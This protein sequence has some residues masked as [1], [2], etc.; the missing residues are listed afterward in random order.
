LTTNLSAEGWVKKW[1][2]LEKCA[3]SGRFESVSGDDV[4]FPLTPAL[5]LGEREK[6]CHAY[7]RPMITDFIQRGDARI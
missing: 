1:N 6:F 4:Y 2:F 5:S 3:A 7:G